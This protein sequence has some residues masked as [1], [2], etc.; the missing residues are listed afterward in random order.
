VWEPEVF[1]SLSFQLSFLAVLFIGFSIQENDEEIP[2]GKKAVRHIRNAFF[3]TVAAL[4]GTAPLVAYAFHYFSIISPLSNLYRSRVPAHPLVCH[5]FSS[6]DHRFFVLMPNSI[7]DCRYQH[8]GSNL[9]SRIPF[10]GVKVPAFPRVLIS[11]YACFSFYFL[12]RKKNIRSSSSFLPFAVSCPCHSSKIPQRVRSST[13]DRMTGHAFR[14][15][16]RW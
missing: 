15:G 4:L 2:S 9:F 3:M 11:Y 13:S 10:A 8:C 7:C 12:F 16:K 6:T 5:L 14:T 1:F